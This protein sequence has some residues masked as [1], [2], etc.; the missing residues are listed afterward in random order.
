MEQETEAILR[1]CG[2]DYGG[3]LPSDPPDLGPSHANM[4]IKHG[5]V[6]DVKVVNVN[7]TCK[8]YC[9]SKSTAKLLL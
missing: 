6:F 8:F 9:K 5:T 7:F 3:F 2:D 4:P 1:L